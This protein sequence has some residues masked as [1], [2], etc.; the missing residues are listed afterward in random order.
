VLFVLK[1]NLQEVTVKFLK[2]KILFLAFLCIY[3]ESSLFDDF[4]I[5]VTVKFLSIEITDMD[6]AT[7]CSGILTPLLPVRSRLWSFPRD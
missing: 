4:D 3:S 7:M 1:I 5:Q 6:G 2:F